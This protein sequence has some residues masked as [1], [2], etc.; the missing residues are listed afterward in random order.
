MRGARS[1]LERK[2]NIRVSHPK[3]FCFRTEKDF[4]IWARFWNNNIK[5]MRK[6][7]TNFFFIKRK[8]INLILF[9]SNWIGFMLKYK[10]IDRSFVI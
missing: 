8:K 4:D 1:S 7:K 9:E 3:I 6:N 10:E 5:N 2:L